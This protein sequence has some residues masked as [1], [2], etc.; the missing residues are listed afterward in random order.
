M[1]QIII[2]PECMKN[3]NVPKNFA[4]HIIKCPHCTA[5]MKLPTPAAT[6][7]Q[8]APAP[9]PTSNNTPSPAPNNAPTKPPIPDN[10]FGFDAPKQKKKK[11]ASS[12]LGFA[13]SQILLR[14]KE[15]K[16]NT[17]AAGKLSLGLVIA[18]QICLVLARVPNY[19]VSHAIWATLP[20]VVLSVFVGFFAK[21]KMKSIVLSISFASILPILLVYIDFIRMYTYTPPKFDSNPQIPPVVNKTTNPQNKQR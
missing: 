16:K 13:R 4:G 18:A 2:C 19:Y 10:D 1:W 17:G 20:L 12:S 8:P 7:S 6:V 14:Y 15:K 5:M 11:R 3:I 21:D 9:T